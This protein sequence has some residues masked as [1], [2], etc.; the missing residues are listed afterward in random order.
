MAKRLEGHLAQGIE[1][2]VGRKATASRRE[3]ISK[4]ANS[5]FED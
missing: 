4:L 5:L 2:T 3:S 1:I